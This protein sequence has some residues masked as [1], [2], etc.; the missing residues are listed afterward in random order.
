MDR[1][2]SEHKNMLRQHLEATATSG[3]PAVAALHESLT[4]ALKEIDRLHAKFPLVRCANY[5][6]VFPECQGCSF[7]EPH[8]GEELSAWTYCT[9]DDKDCLRKFVQVT[10]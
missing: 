10:P 1:M 2:S 5:M 9:L 6:V 3:D 8:D 4:A 7:G